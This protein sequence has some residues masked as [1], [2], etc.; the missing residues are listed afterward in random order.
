M[1]DVAAFKLMRIQSNNSALAFIMKELKLTNNMFELR[2]FVF[3]LSSVNLEK[4]KYK[5]ANAARERECVI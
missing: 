2:V 3:S 5:P 1:F 4:K